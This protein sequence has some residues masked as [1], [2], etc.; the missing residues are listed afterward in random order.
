MSLSHWPGFS[1][2]GTLWFTDLTL[3]A[4]K[5]SQVVELDTSTTTTAA[6]AAAAVVNI[7][8]MGIVGILLPAC[9]LLST[10]TAIQ[11]NFKPINNNNNSNSKTVANT[12]TILSDV[13]KS[14]FEAALIPVAILTLFLPQGTLCYWATSSSLAALQS[15]AMKSA[16]VKETLGVIPP[17]LDKTLTAGQI[18]VLN[19]AAQ[20][21]ANG[22]HRDGIKVLLPLLKQSNNHPRVLFALGTMHSAL[23]EW[24][25]AA[26]C[27]VQSAENHDDVYLQARAW[28]AAVP[29][30]ISGHKLTQAGEAL[31]RA[32]Q[33][34]K[35]DADTKM[36]AELEQVLMLKRERGKR[37]G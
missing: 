4:V 10:F 30:L 29:G 19:T 34:L 7:T 36:I 16:T 12:T 9:V 11:I 35:A 14:L 28:L 32:K 23:G 27:F 15:R 17:P 31:G 24:Q 8:P 18:E 22:Q 1:T 2:G 37:K 13:L 21:A 20:M 6:A 26:E 25:H 33:V 3:P 5:L